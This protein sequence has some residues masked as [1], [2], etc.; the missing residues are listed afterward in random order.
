MAG[1]GEEVRDD[2]WGRNIARRTFIITVI[3][4]A[5]FVAAIELFIMRADRGGAP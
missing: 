4:A 2:N 3:T 1:G 5:L